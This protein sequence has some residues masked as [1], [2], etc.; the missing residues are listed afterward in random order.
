M[1]PLAASLTLLT[2][3][4]QGYA[5]VVSPFEL[6]RMDAGI[7]P[8]MSILFA[9]TLESPRLH[10]LHTDSFP[11]G[12]EIFDRCNRDAGACVLLAHR[13]A[14]ADAV[15]TGRAARV[16]GGYELRL[17]A[18]LAPEKRPLGGFSTRGNTVDELE[19]SLVRAAV[20]FRP[21]VLER[22]DEQQDARAGSRYEGRQEP[23]FFLK[24]ADGSTL[25]EEF[26][27]ALEAEGGELKVLRDPKPE[28]PKK[29]VSKRKKALVD[30]GPPPEPDAQLHVELVARGASGRVYLWMEARG[31]WR[32][33]AMRSFPVPEGSTQDEVVMSEAA[34]VAEAILKTLLKLGGDE[35]W[36]K[37]E[38]PADMELPVPGPEATDPAP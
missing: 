23:P 14:N 28:P 4:P 34:G 25:P 22:L 6:H 5:I 13:L 35:A 7:E 24:V 26:L 38:Q 21:Y 33:L 16:D 20:A 11:A 27:T 1:L 29:R 10:A 8:E 37:A 17:R 32:P 30:A 2:A 19:T 3:L 36:R 12:E 31:L 15:V 9:K 18:F